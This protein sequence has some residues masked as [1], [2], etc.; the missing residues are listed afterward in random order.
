MS[1]APGSTLPL[2]DFQ[3]NDQTGIMYK[4]TQP[5]SGPQ[6]TIG[7]P[8]TV[9]YTGWILLNPDKVGPTFDSSHKRN[10]PFSFMVGAGQVIKGWDLMVAAMHVGEKRI[11]VLP[12][13]MAY[14]SRGAGGVIA[15]NSTLIFEIELLKVS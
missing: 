2:S 14:G 13:A 1:I 11:V 3:K 8:A 9:H 12:P 6:A 4:I 7:K 15:P 5:G 10:Q